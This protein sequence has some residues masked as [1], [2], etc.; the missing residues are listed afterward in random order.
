MGKLRKR[1]EYIIKNLDE[2]SKEELRELI[3]E[4]PILQKGYKSNIPEL[5]E[6][7]LQETLSS[8]IEI[9]II[10]IEILE[11]NESEK[12]KKE[13]IKMISLDEAEKLLKFL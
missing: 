3:K 2:F 8:L 13:I 6:I 7:F 1:Y 12:L 9:N 11:N 10:E 4:A 5:E